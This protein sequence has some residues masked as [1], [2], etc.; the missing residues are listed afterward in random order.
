MMHLFVRRIVARSSAAH[1]DNHSSPFL[2]RPLSASLFF[3]QSLFPH[4]FWDLCYFYRLLPDVARLLTSLEAPAS[5]ATP[6]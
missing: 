4:S 5:R 3:P 1:D 6:S 2:I